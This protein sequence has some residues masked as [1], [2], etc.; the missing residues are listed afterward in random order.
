MHVGREKAERKKERAWEEEATHKF[1]WLGGVRLPDANV[2]VVTAGKDVL[3][4][5]AEAHAEDPAPGEVRRAGKSAP[6]SEKHLCMRF[7]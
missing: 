7:V 6:Y 1:D 4:V 3:R 5:A 2:R